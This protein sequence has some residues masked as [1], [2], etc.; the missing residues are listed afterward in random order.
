MGTLLNLYFKGR[1][2]AR[3]VSRPASHRCD[4][5]SSPGQ[6]MWDLW[7]T[8]WHLCSFLRVLRFP[9]SILVPPT[10]PYSSS[11][12]RGWYNRPVSGRYQ[13]DSVATH[14]KKLKKKKCIYWNVANRN[15]FWFLW[16]IKKRILHISAEPLWNDCSTE[17]LC[18]VFTEWSVS[19]HLQVSCT[20]VL[21]L[22]FLKI[23]LGE[24]Y[25]AI[26]IQNI[27]L[28]HLLW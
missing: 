6:I 18:I 5:G 1:A 11:I 19:W 24:K 26:E 9:L 3:A 4:P 23:V 14:P 7:W 17:N 25:Y 8:N 12:I 10:A 13:V 16:R 15:C 27:L 20:L 2:I 28:I 21:K 22:V